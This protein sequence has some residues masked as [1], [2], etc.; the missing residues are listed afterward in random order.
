MFLILQMYTPLN[1]EDENGDHNLD[2][3]MLVFGCNNGSCIQQAFQRQNQSQC[4]KSKGSSEKVEKNSQFVNY[5][6]RFLMGGQGVIR[7]IRTQQSTNVQ[8]L[9][10]KIDKGQ[11]QEYDNYPTSNDCGEKEESNQLL[12]WGD[13]DCQRSCSNEDDDSSDWGF[14]HQD[15]KSTNQDSSCVMDDIEAMVAAMELN[16]QAKAQNKKKKCKT[17]QGHSRSET[18]QTNTGSTHSVETSMNAFPR[19]DLDV[20]DEP[21]VEKGDSDDEDV[22]TNNIHDD[23]AVQ[24]LLSKYLEQEEDSDIVAVIRS[25]G[26][27][28]MPPCG[29]V[30]NAKKA[31]NESFEKYEKLPPDDRAFL[32]FAARI[33]RAPRQSV[34]YEYGG[35]PIWSM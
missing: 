8:L 21:C 29:G 31:G 27:Q 24:S 20:Y 5:Q 26:K 13:D 14:Q 10:S 11:C 16:N 4:H 15:E 2:R 9:H 7:C 6:D 12:G 23:A 22:T 30:G 18:N 28:I 33:K 19:F 1:L 35:T 17:N 32:T 3:T 34:R 25:G